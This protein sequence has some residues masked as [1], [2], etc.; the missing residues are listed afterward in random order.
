MAFETFYLFVSVQANVILDTRSRQ[1]NS[2]SIISLSP[3]VGNDE[4]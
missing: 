1:P 4:D 2:S 3:R